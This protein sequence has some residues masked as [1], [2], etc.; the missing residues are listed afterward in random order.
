MPNTDTTAAVTAPD[1]RHRHDISDR[2]RAIPEPIRPGG[3]GKVGCLARNNRRFINVVFQVPG[4]GAP[5]AIC[6][7]TMA[8]AAPSI[9]GLA[10]GARTEPGPPLGAVSDD[11]DLEW[12]TIDS[13]YVKV[14]Q[15]GTGAVGGN[16][17]RG[18][19]KGADHQTPSGGGR[20]RN[21]G[22]AAG[23]GGNGGRLYPGGGVD[24]FGKLKERRGEEL[25]PEC[26]VGPGGM[27]D[28]RPGTVGQN[29]LT[30]RPGSR[31][32]LHP[33]PGTAGFQSPNAPVHTTLDQLH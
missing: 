8:T 24:G 3:L 23:R 10:A 7:R 30:T 19:P 1:A 31:C 11:P 25:R 4:T 15:H 33:V 14:H 22:S 32:R 12:L 6:P 18:A 13:S 16:Q 9:A 27:P 5:R 29:N 2:A 28:T 26:S 17:A 20:P 21:A